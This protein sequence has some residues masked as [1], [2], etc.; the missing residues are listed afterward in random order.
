MNHDPHCPSRLGSGPERGAKLPKLR[1]AVRFPPRRLH[2]LIEQR[3][4][5]LRL[6]QPANL[7]PAS[8]ARPGAKR[9]QEGLVARHLKLI[10]ERDDRR[11]DAL[12][13][14]VVLGLRGG[15][16]AQGHRRRLESVG[17]IRIWLGETDE[18]ES[19]GGLLRLPETGNVVM[20]MNRLDL[21]NLLLILASVV[22]VV[23][24]VEARGRGVMR[25]LYHRQFGLRRGVMRLLYHRQFG[26]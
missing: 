19:E 2:P 12:H 4:L 9:P 8:R 13:L 1:V 6:A 26:F 21:D 3:C 5:R 14:D 10:L 24:T 23:A 22:V 17:V 18:V 16:F 20:V 25:I 7:Q 15:A 11:R